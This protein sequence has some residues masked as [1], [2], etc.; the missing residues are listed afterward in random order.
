MY[1]Q[2]S[3][4]NL[5]ITSDVIRNGVTL[6]SSHSKFSQICIAFPKQGFFFCHVKLQY[7]NI[8]KEKSLVQRGC[9]VKWQLHYNITNYN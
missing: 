2:G 9:H 4:S 5:V 6:V 8:V 7:D 1:S 3:F